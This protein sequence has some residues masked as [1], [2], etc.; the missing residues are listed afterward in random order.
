M[1]GPGPEFHHFDRKLHQEGIEG[2]IPGEWEASKTQ[3]MMIGRIRRS[4]SLQTWN[5]LLAANMGTW[6][7]G[8]WEHSTLE[9]GE[10]E[11]K[12]ESE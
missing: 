5:M 6:E 11:R 1:G 2:N 9:H 12:S 10:E 7:H 4:A 8:T 3:S